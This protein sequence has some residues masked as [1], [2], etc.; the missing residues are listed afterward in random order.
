MM[1]KLI[2]IIVL[3]LIPL[4]VKAPEETSDKRQAKNERILKDY[5]YLK[6][7]QSAI[8]ALKYFE[9]LSLI[10]YWDYSQYSIGYGHGILP[11]ENFNKGITEEEA[12]LLLRLDLEKAI[13]TV[14][15]YSGLDRYEEPSKV[16]ALASFVFNVGSGNFL[17]STLLQELLNGNC[18]ESEILRWVK[19]KKGSNY[20]INSHLKSRRMFELE[21]YNS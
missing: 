6:Y 18:I 8:E 7:Y 5:E 15:K 21:M 13:L 19:V 14:E 2:W 10:K 16:L 9:G 3:I 17:K 4:C 12:E 11:Y 20:I 1:K